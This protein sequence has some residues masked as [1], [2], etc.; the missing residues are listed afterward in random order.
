MLDTLVLGLP[1]YVLM[2]VHD[3][4]G[5]RSRRGVTAA[6][7]A[8]VFASASFV[9]ACGGGSEPGSSDEPATPGITVYSGRI[10]PLIGP[11]IDAY[12]ERVDRDVQVRFGDTATL[13]ATVIEE[14]DAAPAD[15]FL[16]QDAGALDALES[17]GALAELPQDILDG[18]KPEYRSPEGRWVGVTA[19][20]RIVAYGPEVSKSELPDSVLDFTDPEWEGRVGWAPTNASLQ[21]Y[22][23]ALRVTEGDEVAREWLEGMVANDTEVYESNVPVRDAVASGEID[24]GLINH[25]YVAQAVAEEGPDYPVKIY[26]PRGDLGSMVNVAGTGVLETSDEPEE[27]TDFIRFLL[28]PKAQRYFVESSKEY[29]MIDGVD[30]PEGVPHLDRIPAPPLDLVDLSGLEETLTMMREAG[31]L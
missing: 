11:M 15:V 25:Y 27:A 18:V 1:N 17:E 8:C 30:P 7:L 12:E 9:A 24:V 29:P 4:N 19:R 20:S 21:A 2:S 23:T 26:Y 31:A 6:L 3:P 28:S 5:S 14:G 13:A 16:S 22:V 10:P